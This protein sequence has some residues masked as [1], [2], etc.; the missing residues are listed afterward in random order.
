VNTLV[1]FR[2]QD[3]SYVLVSHADSRPWFKN[4]SVDF[5]GDVRADS[6]DRAIALSI[7]RQL[8]DRNFAWIPKDHFHFAWSEVQDRPKRTSHTARE[9]IRNAFQTPACRP[10]PIRSAATQ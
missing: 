10:R 8:V 4:A 5:L 3:G 6:F 9:S 1:A 7:G 2:C